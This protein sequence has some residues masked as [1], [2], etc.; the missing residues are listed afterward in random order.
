MVWWDIILAQD[1]R[2]LII[3]TLEFDSDVVF[4]GKFNDV[5][6]SIHRQSAWHRKRDTTIK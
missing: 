2:K 3:I 6:Q 4:D 1:R 5:S